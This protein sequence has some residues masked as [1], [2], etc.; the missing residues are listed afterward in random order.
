MLRNTGLLN[1][2]DACALSLPQHKHDE[3]PAALM[4]GAPKGRDW[5]LLAVATALS[6]LLG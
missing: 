4:L 3:P 1:L 5:A 2:A 6:P